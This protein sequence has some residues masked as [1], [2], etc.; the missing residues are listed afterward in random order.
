[1]DPLFSRSSGRERIETGGGSL[2][3][4]R[5]KIQQVS[6]SRLNLQARQAESLTY[7]LAGV[8]QQIGRRKGS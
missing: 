1:V 5:K 6:L 8:V 2:G 7:G 4:G 3:P